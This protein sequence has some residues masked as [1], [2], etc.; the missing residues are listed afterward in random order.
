MRRPPPL[1]VRGSRL[2]VVT[3][4]AVGGAATIA[5]F[6]PHAGPGL[7]TCPVRGVLGLDCPGCG[8]LRALHDLGHG[9]LVAALDHN[10]VLVLVLP[11]VLVTLGRW[12]A[13]RPPPR[14]LTRRWTPAAAL[15]VLVAWTVARNL[16]LAPL[17]VLGS[18][19]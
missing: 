1:S 10:V 14:L 7:L 19:A 12:V 8:S 18:A 11:L 3:A 2:A 5:R 4:G 15:T 6:D 13:G 17:A 9:Q 16:P